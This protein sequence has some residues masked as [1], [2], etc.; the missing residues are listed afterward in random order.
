MRKRKKLTEEDWAKVFI[1]R[2]Q[3]KQGKTITKEERIL[4]DA[5]FKEDLNRYSAMEKDV[6]NATVPF[7]S[8]VRWK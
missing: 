4:V 7:G 5:A 2:C 8:V 6:F 3:S 1:A